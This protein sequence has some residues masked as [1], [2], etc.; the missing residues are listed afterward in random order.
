MPS[1]SRRVSSSAVLTL[2]SSLSDIGNR[3]SGCGLITRT[4]ILRSYFGGESG[5]SEPDIRKGMP[6]VKLPREEFEK[7]YRSR[8]A[9]PAFKPLQRELDAVIAAAWDGYINSRKAPNTR[10]AGE[11]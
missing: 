10:K 5:R 3:A 6:P 1:T 9:D 2:R 8:F 4:V 7:R 11:G